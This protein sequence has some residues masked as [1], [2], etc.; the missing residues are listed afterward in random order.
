MVLNWSHFAGPN[1]T[2]EALLHKVQNELS[3]E[4]REE[5]KSLK[6]NRTTETGT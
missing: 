6:E 2:I 4:I 5:I 3:R 1:N